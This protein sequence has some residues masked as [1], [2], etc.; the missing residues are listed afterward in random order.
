MKW[1]D[2]IETDDISEFEKQ[3][4]SITV[5]ASSEKSAKTQQQHFSMASNSKDEET[6]NLMKKRAQ[7]RRDARK[8]DRQRKKGIVYVYSSIQ[9]ISPLIVFLNHQ[10]LTE[11]NS[12]NKH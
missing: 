6:K 7:R 2:Y 11:L 4:V 9:P 5:E 3:N 10:Q 1:S 8:R 12:L